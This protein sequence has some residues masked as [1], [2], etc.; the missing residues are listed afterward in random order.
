V[1]IIVTSTDSGTSVDLDEPADHTR[2]DVLVIGTRSADVVHTALAEAEVGGLADHGQASIRPAAL[3]R[4]AGDI[5]ESW[6]A[7]FDRMV[8]Y[9]RAKGWVN[10]RTQDLVAHVRWPAGNRSVR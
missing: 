4:L 6:Q 8:E 3:R 10:E 5:D 1:H 7:S 9:A 2:L